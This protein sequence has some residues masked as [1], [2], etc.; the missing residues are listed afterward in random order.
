[1]KKAQTETPL[2]QAELEEAIREELRQLAD[3]NGG[4]LTPEIVV[5]AARQEDSPLHTAFEWD[6]KEAAHQYRIEQARRLIRSVKVV[7]T[8]EDR[9]VKIP[10]FVRD[11]TREPHVPGYV[12]T[13]EA[14]LEED[15]A[16]AILL[17]EILRI[18]GLL[19]RC[20]AI[21]MVFG[22]EGDFEKLE[23]SVAALLPVIKEVQRVDG[24]PL[25]A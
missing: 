9:A 24:A 23:L 19:V 8:V 1:M 25:A 13:Q 7:V 20:K 5:D 14:A 18:R 12:R 21:S 17:A 15:R 6:N 10:M 3:A 4:L 11:S 16:R 2:D 22:L